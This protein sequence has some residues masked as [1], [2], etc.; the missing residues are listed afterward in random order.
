MTPD[1][2]V[3]MDGRSWPDVLSERLVRPLVVED[4]P[5]FIE[6]LLLTVHGLFRRSSC[7]G[8]ERAVHA[9]VCTVLFGVSGHDPFDPDAEPDPP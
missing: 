9:F 8:F 7:F 1:T 3:A 5:E 2:A 4:V 6:T